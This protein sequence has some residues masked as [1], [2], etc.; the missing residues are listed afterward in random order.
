MRPRFLLFRPAPLALSPAWRHFLSH[1]R[2][3]I[4]DLSVSADLPSWGKVAGLRP[5]LQRSGA[6]VCQSWRDVGDLQEVWDCGLRP[7]VGPGVE[8]EGTFRAAA[9][10]FQG[11]AV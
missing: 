9:S 8:A 10:F 7:P 1:C 6:G 4:P 5:N 3:C 11:L 2:S